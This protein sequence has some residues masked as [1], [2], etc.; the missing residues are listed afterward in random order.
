M[1]QMRE[2]L[3][4]SL[5]SQWAAQ[6]EREAEIA[7][8]AHDLK[9]PLTSIIGAAEAAKPY[10]TAQPLAA[11]LES[12]HS[13]ALA[14]RRLIENLLDMARMQESGPH[15]NMQWHCHHYILDV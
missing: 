5:S 9:T 14:M 11:L 15:L 13:Q 12:M 3:Y 1:E 7:A 8:L 6:Q 4:S 2:A 10:A